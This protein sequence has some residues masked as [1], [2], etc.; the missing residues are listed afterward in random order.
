[1]IQIQ[2]ISKLK[3]IVADILSGLPLDGNQETIHKSTY[4]K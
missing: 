1:M 2:N 4:K 3:K